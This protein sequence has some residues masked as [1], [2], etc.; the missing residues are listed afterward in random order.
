MENE[1]RKVGRIMLGITLTLG[2]TLGVLT[3]TGTG[4]TVRKYLAGFFIVLLAV[5]GSMG[6]MESNLSSGPEMQDGLVEVTRVVDGD[7][8]IIS[9]ERKV[10]LLGINA[11]ESGD[12]F[13][14]ESRNALTQLI[15]GEYVDLKKD[16]SG[17]DNFGRLLRYVSLPSGSEYTDDIFVNQYLLREGYADIE[18]ASQDRV[19]R[20]LLTSA[21][22]RAI[23]DRNGMWEACEDREETAETEYP[24]EGNDQST[25]PNCT[26]KGN[27][28]RLNLG[29]TYF[30]V[31]CSNYDKVKIDFSKGEQY[32]CTEEEAIE[33]GFTK[34]GNCR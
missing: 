3:L 23:M 22:N 12:C 29:K 18:P 5:V 21:R 20:S 7:T 30:L 6:S 1:W 9:G 15:E 16:I 11:P 34:S 14:E 17:M 32:F 24:L 2:A 26:I 25:D 10:R 27:I 4:E 13:Y 31:G 8:I 33:S 19:Y 28:S